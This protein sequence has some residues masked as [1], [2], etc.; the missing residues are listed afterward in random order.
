[1]GNTTNNNNG[2]SKHHYDRIKDVRYYG[3]LQY[4]P[5]VL[6]K[7]NELTSNAL[8]IPYIPICCLFLLNKNESD[9]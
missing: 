7:L 5:R 6:L 1:M 2:P 9:L 8:V 3:F 4:I